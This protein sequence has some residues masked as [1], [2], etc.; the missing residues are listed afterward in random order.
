[1]DKEV[2]KITALIGFLFFQFSYFSN[3]DMQ[4]DVFPG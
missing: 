2:V 4:A 3:F 1:M